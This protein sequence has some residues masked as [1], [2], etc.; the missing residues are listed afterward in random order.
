MDE[1]HVI[2]RMICQECGVA[3]E[4]TEGDNRNDYEERLSAHVLSHQE[5]LRATRSEAK[6]R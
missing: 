4:L 6:G 5:L 1:S 3:F 2:G